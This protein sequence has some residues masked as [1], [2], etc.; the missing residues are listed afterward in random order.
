MKNNNLEY[1]CVLPVMIDSSSLS[2]LDS[3]QH[4]RIVYKDDIGGYLL[5]PICSM[6]GSRRVIGKTSAY[7]SQ[8][9]LKNYA[10][11][12]LDAVDIVYSGSGSAYALK[13]GSLAAADSSNNVVYSSYSSTSSA[14]KWTLAA[15]YDRIQT[16]VGYANM[17]VVFPLNGNSFTITSGYGYRVLNNNGVKK[18]HDGLDVGVYKMSVNSPF[19]GEVVAKIDSNNTYDDRGNFVVIKYSSQNVYVWFYHM[20]SISVE[21]GDVVKKIN[22]LV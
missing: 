14:Q 2:N 17:D 6:N 9:I 7:G 21:V 11:A 1:P 12:S 19:S 22:K 15:D 5:Y 4:F 18:Y 3:N 13:L 16:E 8:I 10:S 20:E